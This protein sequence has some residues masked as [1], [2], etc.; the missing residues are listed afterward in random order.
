MKRKIK[1]IVV[2]TVLMA[3]NLVA[4]HKLT[5]LTVVSILKMKESYLKNAEVFQP[6]HFLIG[7]GKTL[8]QPALNQLIS[9]DYYTQH[10][11]FFC[12]KELQIEKSTRIPMRFRLGSLEY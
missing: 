1:I 7:A 5:P 10:F 11:G 3:A 6:G 8:T 4:Q 2:L 9:A 12:R